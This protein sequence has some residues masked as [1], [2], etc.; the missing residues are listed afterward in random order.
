MNRQFSNREKILLGILC[1][2]ILFCVYYIL[3]WQPVENTLTSAGERQAAA[4]ME[5]DIQQTRL[6]KLRRMRQALDSL[7]H[8]AEADVPDYDNARE[9]VALLNNAMALSN[10]YSL[11]FQPVSF[12]GAIASRPIDMSFRCDDY[13]TVKQILAI[14][15]NSPFRCRITSL[16][17]SCVQGKDIQAQEVSVQAS[18]VFYEYLSPEQRG[19]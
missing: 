16:S 9:V 15:E 6:I 12:Q 13:A 14:L 3:V 4:E 10:K 19:Q 5:L 7:D 2:L 11:T 8:S 1:V 17:V 18:I